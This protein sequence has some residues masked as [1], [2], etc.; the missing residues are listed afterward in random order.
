MTKTAISLFVRNCKD[1]I[2]RGDTYEEAMA[3]IKDAIK[4]HVEDL[5]KSK[6]NLPKFDSISFSTVLKMPT[7]T[8]AS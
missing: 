7:L 3:N 8:K 1:V 6:E 4:L 2:P 5:I